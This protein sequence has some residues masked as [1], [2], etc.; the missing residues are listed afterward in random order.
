[1]VR[2]AP[3]AEPG[4]GAAVVANLEVL[5]LPSA[6]VSCHFFTRSESAGSF[7]AVR[8]LSLAASVLTAVIT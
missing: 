2:T 5:D 4:S 3:G 6:D 1:M 8:D 7:L